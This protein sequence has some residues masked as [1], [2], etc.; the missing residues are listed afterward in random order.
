MTAKPNFLGF[1]LLTLLLLCCNTQGVTQDFDYGQIENNKYY[2]SFFNFEMIIPTGWIVQSKEQTENLT[3]KGADLVA[4]DDKNLKAVIKASE[5]NSANLLAIF[6]YEVGAAVDYNPSI[7]LIS[8]NLKNS[9][10][11][12]TGSDYLFQV[13]KM[14]KQSQVQY[15]YFDE[16]FKKKTINGQDLFLMN[17]SLEY[18]GLQIKQVYYSTIINGFSL[19]IIISFVSKEQKKEIGKV[20]NSMQ[21]RK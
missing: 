10:G 5:V 2:N 19:G 1:I 17:A 15:D 4:G 8:E 20:I 13:R 9:P 18:M 16:N 7:M 12:K 11:I 6:K 14:L 21:F 3:K